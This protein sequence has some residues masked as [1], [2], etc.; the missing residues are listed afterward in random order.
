MVSCNIF[1]SPLMTTVQEHV[2]LNRLLRLE[3][4]YKRRGTCSAVGNSNS[5]TNEPTQTG[6]KQPGMRGKCGSGDACA[7]NWGSGDACAQWTS[8][9]VAA[10]MHAHNC[11]CVLS[12]GGHY[13][14]GG[15]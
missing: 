6:A 7:H 4:S 10:K 2:S 3:A 12:L 5:G 13:N 9:V 14:G 11:T 8:T 1:D 15:T